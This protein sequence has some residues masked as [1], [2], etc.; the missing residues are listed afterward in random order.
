M[1]K[2]ANTRLGD[3]PGELGLEIIKEFVELK[4]READGIPLAISA[5]CDYLDNDDETGFYG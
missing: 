5:S 3:I 4:W 1:E 2:N